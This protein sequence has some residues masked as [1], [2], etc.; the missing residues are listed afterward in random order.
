MQSILFCLLGILV[1]FYIKNT[2]AQTYT[3]ETRAL[4][5]HAGDMQIT[6]KVIGN[7][8]Y[9]SITSKNSVNYVLGKIDVD[10]KTSVTYKD[11]VLQ[12]S[13]L[14]TDKNGEVDQFCS[15]SYDGNTYKIQTEKEKLSYSKPITASVVTLY[16]KEPLG[17]TEIFS[18]VFGKM[19]PLSEIK[20]HTYSIKLPDG[21][22]NTYKYEKGIVVEVEVP[23]P[24][25]TAHIRLKK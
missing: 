16:F 19:V 1:T 12:E 21:K 15:V 22:K 10:H 25:G 20:P 3:Y 7:L 5:I 6:R 8:E 13:F 24:V 17:L 23:S 11:G 2:N 4:G 18:E 9:Y 14:R